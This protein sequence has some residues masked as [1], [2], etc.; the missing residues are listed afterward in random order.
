MKKNYF[1]ILKSLTLISL[2]FSQVSLAS[3]KTKTDDISYKQIS[4]VDTNLKK[5]GI[6]LPAVPAAVGNYTPYIISGNMVYI[7]Q[8]ALSDGKIRYP[9]IVGKTVTEE[10]AKT[11]TRQTIL[12]ILSVLNSATN[13]D[14]DRV[15]QVVQ[16]TGFFNAD[17][18][19]QNHAKLMNTASDLMIDI[20]G[21]RGVHTRATVGA[22]S[23]P[24]DSSVEIQA[25]FELYP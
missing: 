5:L 22:K 19:Y 17:D 20:F 11:E 14:L 21:S 3:E 12:N 16:L 6:V 25:I 4:Q 15:K 13:N 7:N 18:G 24:L 9:G 10:Q 8:V 2:L 1:I 23:L